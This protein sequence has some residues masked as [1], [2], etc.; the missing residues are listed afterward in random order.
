MQT[1]TIEHHLFE[2]EELFNRIEATSGQRFL[3]YLIDAILM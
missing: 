1:E 3:N 2:I